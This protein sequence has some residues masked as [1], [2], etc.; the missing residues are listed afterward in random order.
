MS[1]LTGSALL[2]ETAKRILARYLRDQGYA[3][4]VI[5]HNML[6]GAS[7][8]DLT[9]SSAGKQVSIKVKA[10]SY[11]GTDP[12]KI[13]RRELTYYR[14]ETASYGLEAIADTF[15]RQPGWVQRSRAD[16][17]YYYRLVLGQPEEEV[18]ALMEGPDEVFFNEIRVERDDLRVLPMDAL[19]S[20]F[21]TSGDSYMPRP[22]LT[23]GR[24]AWYRIIPEADVERGVAGV[25]RVGSVFAT[26]A[27]R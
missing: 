13:A 9:Y 6:D 18:A 5:A 14:P 1:L 22:V 2:H 20:W 8:I 16:D 7:G 3:N 15:S 19:R 25:R 21:E 26:L 23:D 24:T 12:A 17:L 10:D 11:Y 4:V 27:R